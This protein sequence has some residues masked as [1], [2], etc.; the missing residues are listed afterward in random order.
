M[1]IHQ[2][3]SKCV[4]VSLARH[5]NWPSRTDRDYPII[6]QTLDS[7]CHHSQSFCFEY[8][9]GYTILSTFYVFKLSCLSSSLYIW[10]HRVQSSIFGLHCRPPLWF[11]LLTICNIYYPWS[12]QSMLKRLLLGLRQINVEQR[13][14]IRSCS[15]DRGNFL[16]LC[17]HLTFRNAIQRLKIE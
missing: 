4:C 5:R 9:I 2:C 17:A 14:L 16:A 6:F 7:E 10:N 15:K 13:K 3:Y 12:P 8:G 1:Q 11:S